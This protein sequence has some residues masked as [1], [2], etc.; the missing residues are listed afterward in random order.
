MSDAY[1]STQ[2]SQSRVCAAR[3]TVASNFSKAA[4]SSS[5]VK[6][7][8]VTPRTRT[9]S[10]SVCRGSVSIVRRC[11]GPLRAGPGHHRDGSGHDIMLYAPQVV[12]DK[13]VAVVDKV[14]RR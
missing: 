9:R 1:C 5:R 4:A 12:A 3:S 8:L 10:T 14:G 7:L 13:I 11:E 2:G 6:V